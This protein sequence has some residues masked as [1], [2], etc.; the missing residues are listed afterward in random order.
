M[1][2]LKLNTYDHTPR[3]KNNKRIT[4]SLAICTILL[5]GIVGLAAFASSY[6]AQSF[7]VGITIIFVAVV[8]TAMT[9]VAVKD[10]ERAYIEILDDEILVVDYIFGIKKEKKISLSDITFAEICSA[11][12][13]KTKGYRLST[14]G[15]QYIVFYS[16]KKYLFKIICLP[17]TKD[18]FKQYIK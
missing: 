16:D 6:Y 13:A 9:F 8:M 5:Y 4:T 12:S 17:E 14:L 2:V 18:I 3:P 7:A 15:E 11:Y 10:I 1:I